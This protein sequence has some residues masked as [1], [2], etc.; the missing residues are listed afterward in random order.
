MMEKG[1]NCGGQ[2]D[3]PDFKRLTQQREMMPL[4]SGNLRSN[5]IVVV[6]ACNTGVQDYEALANAVTL[7]VHIQPEVADTPWRADRTPVDIMHDIWSRWF[8]QSLSGLRA[9]SEV[10]AALNDRRAATGEVR[11]LSVASGPE[12][13]R[14]A[15]S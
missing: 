13:S 3:R 8:R 11:S 2:E 1:K 5:H 9:L 15:L 4:R 7:S 10:S 14:R 6:T 12:R